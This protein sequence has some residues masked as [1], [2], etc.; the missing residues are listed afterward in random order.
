[1][2][3]KEK[4]S[5][6]GKGQ[7]EK[8]LSN[9]VSTFD[10]F[11]SDSLKSSQNLFLV[12]LFDS[13]RLQYSAQKI[14]KE[15]Y[16]M[17]KNFNFCKCGKVTISELV[18]LKR[19]PEYSRAYYN[20]VAT[21]Q[22]P[23]LCPVCS[24]RIMSFRASEIAFA[25]HSHLSDP[26]N[27]CYLLTL[28]FKHSLDDSL[29]SSISSMKKALK[30]FW[31]DRLVIKSFSACG[32]VG[33]ITSFEIN[34][35][36][37]Y[38]WHPHEH[39]LIFGKKMD[40][41]LKKTEKTLS[42][43]WLY[44]LNKSGLEGL[45][46]IALDL[47]EARSCDKY[48]QK[49][50]SEMALLNTKQG[51]GAKNFTPFQILEECYLGSKWAVKVFEELFKTTFGKVKWLTWSRGL[52]DHFAINEVSDAD[53]VTNKADKSNLQL[54]ADIPAPVYRQLTFQ[55][56]AVLRQFASLGDQNSFKQYIFSISDLK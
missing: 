22:H 56:R 28:T 13:Y 45:S 15:L 42:K 30:K 2:I 12:S 14:V 40:A 39:I 54:F 24:A 27:T 43:R 48:L 16:P 33:R 36:R 23:A 17:R 20:G 55:D 29:D 7:S 46:G 35:S 49:I 37:D 31:E 6:A 41:D 32:R 8:P 26:D 51:R 50:S 52:K 34:Y 1:M 11:K 9:L 5:L 19:N 53:I 18:E 10:F 44:F 21:C 25:V 47:V 38:G 4:P 3:K